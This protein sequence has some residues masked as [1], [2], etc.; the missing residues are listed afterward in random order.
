MTSK[1]GPRAERDNSHTATGRHHLHSKENRFFKKNPLS[2]I[3]M[4]LQE[5][6]ARVLLGL[7]GNSTEGF[8]L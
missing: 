8:F 1:D 7:H 5:N 3:T 2:T 4:Q 6:P